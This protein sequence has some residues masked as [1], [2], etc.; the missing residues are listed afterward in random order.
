MR[1]VKFKVVI[2]KEIY[3]DVYDYE[4]I[5]NPQYKLKYE[6][7]KDL[8]NKIFDNLPSNISKVS[9]LHIDKLEIIK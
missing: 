4:L 9:S 1:L 2:E 7:H 6:I 3:L 5:S 8:W